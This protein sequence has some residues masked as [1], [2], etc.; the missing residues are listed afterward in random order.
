MLT[1]FTTAKPFKGLNKI[2]QTNALRSWRYICPECEIILF[3]NEEGVPEIATELGICNVPDIKRSENGTPL[4]SD[5]F[6]KVE[7]ISKNHVISYI[8]ADI[9]LMSDFLPAIRSIE[10]Q[11]FLIVGQRRD[12]NLSELIDFENSGW[13]ADLRSQVN[14]TGILHPKTGI[15]YFVFTKGL[16]EDIPPFAIGR[17]T[18]DNWLI[19]K[20]R[21]LKTP[22][23]DATEIIT[24]VHQNHD[25]SHVPNDFTGAW[26]GSEALR[27]RKIAGNN[28]FCDIEHATLRIT[29]GGLKRP[30]ITPR[31]LFMNL[32]SIPIIHPR[33]KFLT[34][35]MMAL[36]QMVVYIRKKL[37]IR[38]PN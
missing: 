2:I 35:P 7:E 16:F 38:K 27:N 18:W 34:F 3:G 20:A 14:E 25:Y 23:I 8:N 17:T 9:I 4:V 33:L 13:E 12:L 15:D 29:D 28:R 1:L 26:K 24:A 19:G 30:S 5:I 10:L 37:K 21:Y 32:L 31:Y 11:K 22:V 36:L 6:S